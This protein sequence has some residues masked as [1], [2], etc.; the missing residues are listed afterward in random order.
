MGCDPGKVGGAGGGANGC[1]GGG[2]DGGPPGV[3]AAVA[4]NVV[5]HW[6]HFTCLPRSSSGTF[7]CL[8]HEGHEV[9]VGMSILCEWSLG[10]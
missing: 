2:G 9:N 1:C 6:G 3:T 10:L 4:V 8:L 7:N 5:P